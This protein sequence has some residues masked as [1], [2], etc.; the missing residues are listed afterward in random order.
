MLLGFPLERGE[1]EWPC[2]TCLEMQLTLKQDK[3]SKFLLT[4]WKKAIA[5]FSGHAIE[6]SQ[7]SYWNNKAQ[8][9]QRRKGVREAR[10]GA[11]DLKARV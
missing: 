11:W 1:G 8:G 5:S 10:S 6:S 3:E 7:C 4:A 9:L 2:T